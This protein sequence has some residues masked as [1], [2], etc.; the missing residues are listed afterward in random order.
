MTHEP[1]HAGLQR[2]LFRRGCVL[3]YGR[4][5]LHRGTWFHEGGRRCGESTGHTEED[6]GPICESSQVRGLRPIQRA[7]IDRSGQRIAAVLV[8]TLIATAAPGIR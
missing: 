2:G 5:E 4:A 7:S 8:V 6:V 1:L 3:A